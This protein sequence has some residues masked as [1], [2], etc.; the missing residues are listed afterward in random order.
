M[1]ELT[2]CEKIILLSG[3]ESKH[4]EIEQRSEITH[5]DKRILADMR[6]LK[7]AIAYEDIGM[8]QEDPDEGELAVED[9]EYCAY[10]IQLFNPSPDVDQAEETA[11]NNSRLS[12]SFGTSFD[13]EV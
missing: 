7:K 6:R 3:L 10:L 4:K 13:K 12:M 1:R 2:D 11:E 5:L 9:A 8:I